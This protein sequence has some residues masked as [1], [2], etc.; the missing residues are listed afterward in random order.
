MHVCK[1]APWILLACWSP[2]VGAKDG[3]ERLTS[4]RS[5]SGSLRVWRQIDSGNVSKIALRPETRRFKHRC[6][7]PLS[8]CGDYSPVTRSLQFQQRVTDLYRSLL[9]KLVIL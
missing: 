3:F 8:L 7:P 5:R 9:R 1:I 4:R 6:G 2:A